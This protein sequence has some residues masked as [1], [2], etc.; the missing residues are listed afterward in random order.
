MPSLRVL[1]ED[2]IP[3]LGEIFDL[4]KKFTYKDIFYSIY[5]SKL[6]ENNIEV[7]NLYDF[8]KV[9]DLVNSNLVNSKIEPIDFYYE[10]NDRHIILLNKKEKMKRQ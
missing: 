3:A 6:E 2:I 7:L 10:N 4:E 5:E 9:I 8:S 1:L